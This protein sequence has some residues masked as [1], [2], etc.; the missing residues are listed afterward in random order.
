MLPAKSGHKCSAK[1]SCKKSARFH[2]TPKSCW[3]SLRRSPLSHQMAG[4]RDP[5]MQACLTQIGWVQDLQ[6]LKSVTLT[7]IGLQRHRQEMPPTTVSASYSGSIKLYML[8]HR[9]TPKRQC[10]PFHPPSFGF[11]GHSQGGA[12]DEDAAP[13]P[14]RGGAPELNVLVRQGPL[15][16]WRHP[17]P[18]QVP[19]SVDLLHEERQKKVH[20]SLPSKLLVWQAGFPAAA[21][22][23]VMTRAAR[24][25]RWQN[26]TESNHVLW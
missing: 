4:C 19:P 14:R 3:L 13:V 7:I 11:Q 22:C 24:P 9:S 17:Q 26:C 25:I 1:L 12:A 20:L 6:R 16:G 5:N 15:I 2:L 8:P 10:D 23:G 21:C 18:H